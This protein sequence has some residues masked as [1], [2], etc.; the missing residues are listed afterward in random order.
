MKEFCG[1]KLRGKDRTCR[2]S[3]MANGR[4][5][6]HG[7]LTPSGPES[8]NYVH[9]RYAESFK[10]VLAEKFKEAEGDGKPLDLL[11]ELYVQRALLSQ[12]IETVTKKKTPGI[13]DLKRISMLVED[14]VKTAATIAKVRNDTALTIAEVRFF[15]SSVT[16][17]LEKYVP[18]P[19]KR[20]NFISE[21]YTL[22]PGRDGTE[23]RQDEESAIGDG[24]GVITAVST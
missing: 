18:D 3:P 20:R 21:L 12:Y 19:D 14:V 11:P 8:A 10:G 24:R 4:C 23:G 17:L 7:G 16:R 9:G 15:Q 5:R 13:V 6:L 2:K 22:I 1:A